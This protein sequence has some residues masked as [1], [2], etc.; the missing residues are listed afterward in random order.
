MAERRP[1]PHEEILLNAAPE[2]G[3]IVAHPWKLIVRT[4][5][6]KLKSADRGQPEATSPDQ[7]AATVSGAELY[8][9]ADDPAERDNLAQQR[10]DKVK[11]LLG[12]YQRLAAQAAPPKYK[13]QPPDFQGP[14]V[15][16]EPKP[17]SAQPRG[18]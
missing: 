1:S 9:L 15:W 14:V 4:S 10:P 12:R 18:R 13:P 6:R 3:A 8:H 17:H 16:G 2:G 7:P 5:P 11:E